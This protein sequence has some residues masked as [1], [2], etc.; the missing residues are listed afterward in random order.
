MQ[1]HSETQKPKSHSFTPNQ[2]MYP[3]HLKSKVF[4]MNYM[5]FH[6]L[7]F[8]YIFSH[9]APHLLFQA[10]SPCYSWNQGGGGKGGLC[11][12]TP[13]SGIHHISAGLAHLLLPGLL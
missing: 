9:Q 13:T 4:T 10:H 7:C 8:L 1:L 6:E 5:F 2:A 12:K 11:S 3:S